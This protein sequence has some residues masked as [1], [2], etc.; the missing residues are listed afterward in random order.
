MDLVSKLYGNSI[1]NRLKNDYETY[2]SNSEK[3]IFEYLITNL[4]KNVMLVFCV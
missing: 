4:H 1:V 3:N 2:C